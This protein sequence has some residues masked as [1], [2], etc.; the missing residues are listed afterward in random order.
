MQICV[1]HLLLQL[2]LWKNKD[3]HTS[4]PICISSTSHIPTSTIK[5]LRH[6]HMLCKSWDI[7]W[8]IKY[9]YGVGNQIYKS[10]IEATAIEIIYQIQGQCMEKFKLKGVCVANILQ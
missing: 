2:E 9:T 5:E 6:V 10:K 8:E 7:W 1:Y 3:M 4:T